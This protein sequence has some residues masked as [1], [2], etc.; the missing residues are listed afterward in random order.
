MVT[1]FDGF[2]KTKKPLAAYGYQGF[3]YLEI[4]QDSNLL[5]RLFA[6]ILSGSP[7]SPIHRLPG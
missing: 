1:Q 7:K 2:L 3:L 6:A 5:C 4:G